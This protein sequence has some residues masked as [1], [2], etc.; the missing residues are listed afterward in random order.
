MGKK[1]KKSQPAPKTGEEKKGNRNKIK[2]KNK[3]K[4]RMSDE[5]RASISRHHV[6]KSKKAY[7][8][9]KEK[10]VDQPDRERDG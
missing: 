5:E 4:R 6:H 2:I 3:H 7:D 9:R 8:R 10:K 1:R